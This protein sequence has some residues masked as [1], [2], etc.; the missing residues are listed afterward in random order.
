MLKCSSERCV[1]APHSLSA[2]TSTT[3]RLSV[4]FRVSAIGISPGRVFESAF[5]SRDRSGN[6][7][8]G[9]TAR[10]KIRPVEPTL[11]GIRTGHLICQGHARLSPGAA[12]VR[13]RTDMRRY[14][15]GCRAERWHLE[16]SRSGDLRP[17]RV[18]TEFRSPDKICS[19]N[20]Q[21]CWDDAPG[22]RQWHGR[23]GGAAIKTRKNFGLSADATEAEVAAKMRTRRRCVKGARLSSI[24][25]AR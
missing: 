11:A 9:S 16:V 20:R 10:S 19:N 25:S 12:A 14:V 8:F 17:I 23:A 6:A 22:E 24:R 2:A 13:E 5:E 21:F 3:P 1:C 15:Q 18:I 7:I 4:S